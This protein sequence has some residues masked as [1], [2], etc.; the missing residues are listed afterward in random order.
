VAKRKLGCRAKGVINS[1]VA[2]ATS[3]SYAAG[4]RKYR[5]WLAANGMAGQLWEPSEELLIDFTVDLG[6]GTSAFAQVAPR[7]VEKYLY[8]IRDAHVRKSLGDPIKGKL[9]LRRAIE[10]LYRTTRVVKK[11]KKPL[12]PKVMLAFKNKLDMVAYNH[13]L[14][15][16]MFTLAFFKMLRVGEVTYSSERYIKRSDLTM[17]TQSGV[18]KLARS[19]TDQRCVGVDLHFFKNGSELCPYNAMMSYLSVRVKS[20]PGSPLFLTKK[21][22]PITRFILLKWLKQLL[23]C[24]GLDASQYG[25]ISFRKG[26]ATFAAASGAT[27]RQ[28]KVAGRWKSDCF[29]AYVNRD[30]EDMRELSKLMAANL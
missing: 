11:T 18:L 4:W 7:T 12:T 23:D 10:G 2:F 21:G 6:T 15:W 22:R 9:L 28:I 27:D 30:K 25:G 5:A 3:K 29:T 26:G 1:G 14:L 20:A 8:A 16:A 24:V 13:R 19:K 17:R